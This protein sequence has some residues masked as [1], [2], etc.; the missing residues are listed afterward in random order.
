[1]TRAEAE[2]LAEVLGNWAQFIRQ[3][4]DDP[5]Q[6]D[7]RTD[8]ILFDTRKARMLADVLEDAAAL[9]RGE[10]T[11][12]EADLKGWED[13]VAPSRESAPEAQATTSDDGSDWQPR[14]GV[15]TKLRKRLPF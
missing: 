6:S 3:L 1:M 5:G 8:A 2:K 4:C 13:A 9:A 7:G 12:T 15:K 11:L 10:L 14:R